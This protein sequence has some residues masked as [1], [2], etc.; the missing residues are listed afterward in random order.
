L[1]GSTMQSGVCVSNGQERFDS[2]GQMERCVC[3]C[4][5]QLQV[6]NAEWLRACTKTLASVVPGRSFMSMIGSACGGAASPAA[7]RAGRNLAQWRTSTAADVMVADT[8]PVSFQPM[9]DFCRGVQT[10]LVVGVTMVGLRMHATNW[11]CSARHEVG[12][13][14]AGPPAQ[15]RDGEPRAELLIG[16]ELESVVALTWSKARECNAP[17]CAEAREDAKACTGAR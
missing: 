15:A 7:S 3:A 17:C 6:R 11:S 14:S 1:Y 9:A 13:T 5:S 12:R 2:A 4:L 16:L 8:L 10:A